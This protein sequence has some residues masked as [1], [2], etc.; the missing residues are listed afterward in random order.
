[1]GN[2]EK[3][4]VDLGE[5]K[6]KEEKKEQPKTELKLE[7]TF[8]ANP[9][10]LYDCLVNQQ[11]VCMYTRSAAQIEA[12]AGGQFSLYGGSIVGEIVELEK[13]CRIVMRWKLKDWSS[14][15]TVT[16]TMA[17][18]NGTKLT[19]TQ[20]DIPSADYERTR[21]GWNNYYWTPI[22]AVFGYN[23]ESK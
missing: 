5:L 7:Y 13:D 14:F 20:K 10:D 9:S 23:F 1:M 2:E 8:Q 3:K 4:K 19:L 17:K 15:S 6:T 12:K 21:S 16:F 11:R 18:H 22:R